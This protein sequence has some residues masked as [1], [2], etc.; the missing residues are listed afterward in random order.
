MCH[1][2]YLIQQELCAA[3]PRITGIVSALRL[4]EQQR[5]AVPFGTATIEV[6]TCEYDCTIMLN[7]GDEY[8]TIRVT[9][10][11]DIERLGRLLTSFMYRAP[12]A[13]SRFIT[14]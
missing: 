5:R 14:F 9:E 1:F 7:K 10:D 11:S 8:L 3:M 13:G 12:C 6:E 2:T 4:A